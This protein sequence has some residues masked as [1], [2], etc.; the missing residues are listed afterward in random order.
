VI[1][2]FSKAG[3]IKRLGAL[4]QRKAAG[5]HEPPAEEVSGETLPVALQQNFLNQTQEFVA[6]RRYASGLRAL[7]EILAEYPGSDHVRSMLA[8]LI[9]S[10]M[11][12][13]NAYEAA[14]Q[15]EGLTDALLADRRLDSLFNECSRCGNTWVPTLHLHSTRKI[16]VTNALGGRCVRCHKVFCRK[17]FGHAFLGMALSIARCP[18]CEGA[19]DPVVE[20]TGRRPRQAARVGQPIEHVLFFREGPIPP[21]SQYLTEVFRRVC[22]EVLESP[23]QP[24]IEVY[25]LEDWTGGTG[26]AMALL[27]RFHPEYLENEYEVHPETGTYEGDQI[28]LLLVSRRREV[29][30]VSEPQPRRLEQRPAP[31][32]AERKLPEE[33][34][35]LFWFDWSEISDGGHPMYGR[36]VYEHLL[37]YF[38]PHNQDTAAGFYG[39]LDGDAITQSELQ[40]PYRGAEEQKCVS[41]ILRRG[42]DVCY[43]VGVYGRG[44]IDLA[45]VHQGLRS[46]AVS[47]YLGMTSCGGGTSFLGL[48]G[49]ISLVPALLLSDGRLRRESFGYL[50]EE[51]LAA[52]GFAV[53]T[54]ITALQPGIDVHT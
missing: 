47:G 13:S 53:E 15:G 46:S 29:K 22:P 11:S 12:L 31:A 32:L 5:G 7:L 10:G 27:A 54:A 33:R 2:K 17:C 20:P 4:F 44:A 48:T 38:A 9:H 43:V 41:E 36:Y 52:M 40:L 42:L 30:Q 8:L 21:D 26:M 34:G 28:C 25:P 45:A 14:P 51:T 6:A 1:S 37:P 19:V 24:T 39:F 23:A 18:E 50:G 35:V 49:Q 16:S 3:L